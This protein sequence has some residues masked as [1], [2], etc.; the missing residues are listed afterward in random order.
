MDD[1]I[2]M[3]LAAIVFGGE[4]SNLFELRRPDGSDVPPFTAGAHIDLHLA[5][6]LVRQYSIAN[7]P[8]ERDRYLLGIKREAQ[9]RGGSRFVHDAV[10]VGAILKVSLP[11]NNFPLVEAAASSVFVAGG[12]GITPIR[13][14]VHRAHAI[15]QDW[16][17]HYAVRRRPEAVF[18]AELL[19]LGDRVRLHVDEESEG[20]LLDLPAV[21]AAAPAGAH[22]YCCGP[23]PMMAAFKAAAAGAVPA[24]RTHLEYFTSD[25]AP[26]VQGGFVVALARSGRRIVVPPGT[27]ILEALRAAGLRVQA[28]CEQGVCG[29]CETQVLEGTPDHRDM[30]L[31]DDEKAA[32]RSM[33][34][35][36]SGSRSEVLVL[37]L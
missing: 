13:S 28:A 2:D 20:R 31:S 9:G 4:G 14:M 22:L 33:M 32:G 26:A 3:R 21:I 29:T 17:L 18:A 34:I 35:C 36:C 37:D 7:A 23:A 16:R 6:G 5:G 19:S 12:I 10:K 11:R 8:G 24:E 27:S 25:T 30:I 1:L 15:G